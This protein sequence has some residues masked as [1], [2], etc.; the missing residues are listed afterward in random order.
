MSPIRSS[1]HDRNY[2]Y[3]FFTSFSLPNTAEP[4]TESSYSR[5]R[6]SATGLTTNTLCR[7]LFGGTNPLTLLNTS[8]T[9]PALQVTQYEYNAR[10]NVTAVVDALGQRYTFSYDALGRVTA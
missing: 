4:C 2:N 6:P 3:D 1:A 8:V 9:D 10:S 7:A 5:D